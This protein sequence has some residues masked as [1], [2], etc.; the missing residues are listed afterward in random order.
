MPPAATGFPEMSEAD[1]TPAA[2][3][4]FEDLKQLSGVPMVALI[5]R[6]LATHPGVLEEVWDA[7]RPLFAAGVLQE[8][9]W[10]AASKSAPHDLVPPIGAPARA[11]L[12]LE[13]AAL[14]RVRDV[15]AAYNRAN[16]VNLAAA[17][18]L[19]ARLRDPEPA[20]RTPSAP[21]AWTPPTA[22][23]RPLVPMTAPDDIDPDLRRLIGELGFG[24]A[25]APDAVVPSL[26]RH[27]AHRP[28]FLVVVHDA[29][30]PRVR[31]GRLAAAVKA[32]RAAVAE[33]G[34]GLA[35]QL[36]ALPVLGACAPARAAL[37][38][39]SAGVIPRMIAIGIGIERAL[40]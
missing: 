40:A 29:L 33:G 12:G 25:G 14:E 35:P 8:G 23:A 22:I 30:M 3:A 32:V 10:Q 6:H 11:A 7:L 38:R 39:F 37:E 20:A 19:L 31:D 34:T 21:A 15:L 26:F 27:F 1:A 36:P 24:A 4:V 2:R 16:P 17:A 18:C 28:A 5:F 9:A 13:G